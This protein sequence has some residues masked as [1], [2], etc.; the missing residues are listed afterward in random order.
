MLALI[1]GPLGRWI[2]G[3]LIVGALLFGI[4]H[5]GDTQ[6][7]ARERAKADRA[8]ND[9]VTGW[10]AR[11]GQC[12]ANVA[13][14]GRAI[15]AQNAAVGAWKAESLRRSAEAAKAV[16]Q[17]QRATVAANQRAGAILAAK[18]G[19]EQCASAEALIMESIR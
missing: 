9:P 12:Q 13:E 5:H 1:T 17:A 3:L 18:P 14:Q 15:D 19:A 16:Q 8:I 7:A 6:G 2:G 4:H 10:K 11:L